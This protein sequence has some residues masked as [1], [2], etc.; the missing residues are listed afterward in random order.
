ML[1]T[2]TAKST[3]GDIQ[4][5]QIDATDVDDVKRAL[6]EKSLYPIDIQKKTSASIWSS[7]FARQD[8]SALRKRDLRPADGCDEPQDHLPRFH[9]WY[10]TAPPKPGPA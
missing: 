8:K 9:H 4:T 7:L 3:A 10:V 1:Y 6:R 2:Y 5:G